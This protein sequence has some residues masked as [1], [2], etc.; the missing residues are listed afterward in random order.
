MI[1]VVAEQKAGLVLEHLSGEGVKAW[2]LGNIVA[3]GGGGV[4]FIG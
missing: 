1:L 4:E 2:Q 3:G